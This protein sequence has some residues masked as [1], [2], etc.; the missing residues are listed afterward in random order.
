MQ[1]ILK[2]IAIALGIIFLSA[3]G[4]YLALV[5]FV[6]MAFLG[7]FRPIPLGK[8]FA[9]EPCHQIKNQAEWF[10]SHSGLELPKKS[11]ILLSCAEFMTHQGESEYYIVFDTSNDSITEFRQTVLNQAE[12]IS[13]SWQSGAIPD[14]LRKHTALNLV[15]DEEF[16]SSDIEWYFERNKGY[17]NLI[18]IDPT[19][20]RIL[21]TSSNYSPPRSFGY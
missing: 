12:K 3:I 1:L 15:F 18:V 9:G 8:S 10:R 20:N 14:T 11:I 13:N 19:R 5:T 6:G 16:T 7:Y 4:F 21:Y 2:K 17:R